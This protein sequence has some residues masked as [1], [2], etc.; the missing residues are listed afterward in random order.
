MNN[1]RNDLIELI[2]WLKAIVDHCN[3]FISYAKQIGIK[4][5]IYDPLNDDDL[6]KISY[7]GLFLKP[8]QVFVGDK[9]EYKLFA[10]NYLLLQVFEKLWMVQ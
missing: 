8:I 10:R 5:K 2:P 3:Y 1:I 6:V 4:E 9:P 7:S